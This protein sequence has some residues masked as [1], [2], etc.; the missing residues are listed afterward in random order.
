MPVRLYHK[1]KLL[2]G[3]K[4]Y[5]VATLLVLLN[6]AVAFGWVTP[7][8]MSQINTI[9]GALGLAALRSGVST[10]SGAGS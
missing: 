10:D 3:Y 7:E 6:L 8:H 2:V 1:M 5:I 9:L 4:T